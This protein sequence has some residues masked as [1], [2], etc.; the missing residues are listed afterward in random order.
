MNSIKRFVPLTVLL[1]LVIAVLIGFQTFKANASNGLKDTPDTQEI[2]K[3]MEKGYDAIHY[4]SQTNDPT[5][6]SEIFVD[7]EDYKPSKDVKDDIEKIYGFG[8]AEK[9][10]YLTAMETKY[11]IRGKVD[12]KMKATLE[13]AKAENRKISK[14]EWQEIIKENGGYAPPSMIYNDPDTKTQL[15]Y[16]KIE[17]SDDKATVYYDDQAAYQKATLVR[18]NNKWFI[19]NIEPIYVHF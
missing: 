7:T 1:V 16:K 12:K 14:E 9:A 2:M 3:A 11:I 8:V 15:T 4:A 6:L 10:G 17:I 13:K 5:K 19:S 18:I